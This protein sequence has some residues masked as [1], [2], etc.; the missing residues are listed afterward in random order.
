M[1]TAIGTP[2]YAPLEQWGSS[3]RFGPTTDVYALAAT[4]YH[5]LT[6]RMPASA[7]DRA[8]EDTLAPP[9]ALS[10][11]VSQDLSDAVM[12]GLAVRMD[13]RPQTM[14]DFAT[15]L[16]A[17]ARSRRSGAATGSV[18]RRSQPPWP[19]A[20]A[21]AGTPAPTPAASPAPAPQPQPQ[22]GPS[23]WQP[24]PR[25]RD[26]VPAP[27]TRSGQ[28]AAP[29]RRRRRIRRPPRRAAVRASPGHG[30]CSPGRAG[31]ATACSGRSERRWRQPAWRCRWSR[32]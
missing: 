28:A 15:A 25:Q 1:M 18:A 5:L 6:G 8:T 26:H 16:R 27:Q 23:S 21:A 11:A 20:A 10:R 30:G 22:A 4:L 32:R 7:A 9:H 17:A 3:G 14:A 24:V 29:A 12:H 2:G 31:A 19:P 13:E